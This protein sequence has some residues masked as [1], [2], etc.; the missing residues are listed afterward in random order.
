MFLIGRAKHSPEALSNPRRLHLHARTLSHHHIKLEEKL[1][2][3][4]FSLPTILWKTKK[5]IGDEGKY[6]IGQIRV[7]A[8][9]EKKKKKECLPECT[10]VEVTCTIFSYSHAHLLAS[11]VCDFT[12]SP[13]LVRLSSQSMGKLIKQISPN[14]HSFPGCGVTV[15]ELSMKVLQEQV[16]EL[17]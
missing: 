14:T 5:E 17:V 8:I 6:W 10:R 15:M 9:M 11:K 7:S 13:V 1:R 3:W 16:W 2:E 12:K 4:V